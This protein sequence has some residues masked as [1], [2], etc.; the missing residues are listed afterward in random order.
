MQQSQTLFGHLAAK[1]VTQQENLATES[2][3][4]ILS[5][6]AVAKQAF[7]R[8]LQV[9]ADVE[10]ATD[11]SLRTQ[12][13]GADAAIPDLVGTDS[14]GREVL[15]VEAKFWAGL[16]PNQPVTYLRRLPD[17]TP[18]VLLFIAPAMR[19]A[20]LWNELLRRSREQGLPLAQQDKVAT[21]FLA[22][23]V[24]GQ[25]VL[26]L[27]SWRIVLSIIVR[28]LEVEGQTDA[29][30]DVRQLAGFCDRMDSDAFLPLHSEELT[31]T[32]GAR[33]RQYCALVDD[34][35]D[36]LASAGVGSTQGLRAAA[37]AGWYA[38]R[39]RIGRVLGS[40]NV[41]AS[42][43]GKYRATPLWLSLYTDNWGVPQ[44]ARQ[45]LAKLEMED[46]PRLLL[47]ENQLT[48]PLTLPVD[49]ERNQV[50]ESLLRQ[51]R[52]VAGYLRDGIP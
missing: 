52:E 33:V 42:K 24:K 30:S 47:V 2:L 7:L 51:V 11:L 45:R 35:V 14:A 8:F 36:H 41:D 32:V 22:R 16:T 1:F 31:S 6:S 4:Y 40:V 15:I 27:A 5:R 26:A 46:P 39:I 19:F 37:G 50:V 34:V 29:A 49:V 20:T 3:H 38:R 25:H 21:E 23:H 18:A 13:S 9:Q 48:I 17:Q 28:A 10:F 43:W 44:A 12:A